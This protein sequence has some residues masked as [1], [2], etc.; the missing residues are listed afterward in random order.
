VDHV[1][2]TTDGEVRRVG[3]RAGKFIELDHERASSWKHWNHQDQLEYVPCVA[4]CTFLN[5]VLMLRCE[6]WIKNRIGSWMV[7]NM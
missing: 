2:W 6:T 1:C 7:V 5:F 3:L 4:Q